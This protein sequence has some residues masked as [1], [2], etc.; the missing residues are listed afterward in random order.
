MVDSYVPEKTREVGVK[1]SIILKDDKPIHQ[2]ARRLAPAKRDVVNAQLNEWLRDNIVQPS[3]SEY[4]SPVVMVKKKDG[5]MRLCVDYRKINTV[6]V[7]DR[8]PMPLVEDQ[9]DALQGARV[10]STLDLRNGFFHVPISEESRKYTSFIVPD[11]QYEFLRVPFGLCNSPAV[12][13][14]YINAVFGELIRK[15]IVL[16]YIDDLIIP[17]NDVETGLQKLE[18]VLS[19]AKDYGL[20]INWK[21]CSLL[22]TEVEFLGHII[23]DGSVR[24]SEHEINAVAKFPEPASTKQVQS[25]LGLTGY[26]RKFIEGYSLIARPLSDLLRA[27]VNFKFGDKERGAF[28]IL[29]GKLCENPI[30]KLYK[31]GAETELHTDASMFGFGA[32][33]LQRDDGDGK[34]HPVYYASGKTTP[35]ESRYTSYELEVLAIVRALKKFRIYLL[36]LH[37]TIVTDCRAFSLTMNKRDLCVRVARWALLLE[38]FDYVIVHRPG[39]RMAHVDALSRNPLPVCLQ[40]T[41]DRDNMTARIR[42]AQQ[43][44]EKVRR[45]FNLA[46]K[47]AIDGYLAKN[48]LLYKI[49]DDDIRLVVPKPLQSQLIRR[50]HENGHFAVGK[51]EA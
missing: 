32:I 28:E 43:D 42:K 14:R 20:N 12:F 50:V 33:L 45:I 34:M 9:L 37:F 41:V 15:Q 19:V 24:P 29:K 22:K 35:A 2:R 8:Y 49:I 17:S 36:G 11:G 7:K 18:M 30:L 27:N 16:V 21:K 13:V 10:Y 44:D 25:F 38:E 46:E 39:S 26:F 47:K 31:L 4:T 6:I 23:R 5:S 40:V 1:M 48:G 3:L 51:T